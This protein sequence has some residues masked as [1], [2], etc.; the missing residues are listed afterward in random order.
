MDTKVLEYII[1]IAEEKSISRAAE[2]Y[3]LSPAAISQHLKKIEENLGAHIFM[4]VNGELCLTDVGKIFINGARSMLYV[5]REALYKI[6]SMRSDLKSCIR[7]IADEN[8]VKQIKIHIAPELKRKFPKIE[9]RLIPGNSEIMKEYLL[10]GMADIG[11]TGSFFYHELLEFIPL[12]SDELVLAM[13]SSNPLASKFEREGFSAEALSSEYFILHKTEDSFRT[14][15]QEAMERLGITAQALCEVSSLSAACHMVENGLG[16]SFLP[17]S[18][19]ATGNTTYRFFRLTPP[20]NFSFS[21]VYPKSTVPNKAFK[22]LLTVLRK[23][24]KD[25]ILCP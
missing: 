24:F 25:Y 18:L 14:V 21:A 20:I 6:G 5:Q 13:P 1:A 11:I 23:C 4:R 16:S 22:E 7:I 19:L 8:T 15:Q 10:N 12:H 2:K 9:L 3:F 17:L